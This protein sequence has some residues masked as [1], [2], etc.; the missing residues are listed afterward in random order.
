MGVG[1]FH[2]TRQGLEPP[3]GKM[4]SFGSGPGMVAHWWPRVLK[5]PPKRFGGEAHGVAL[6]PNAGRVSLVSHLPRVGE[7]GKTRGGGLI[8]LS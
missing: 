4:L 2:T 6:H 7:L 5:A 8:H 3:A 1:R